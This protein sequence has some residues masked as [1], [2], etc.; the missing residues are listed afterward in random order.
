MSIIVLSSKTIARDREFG[1]RTIITKG[2]AYSVS[3]VARARSG[4]VR[5][6]P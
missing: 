5:L 1:I 4:R 3:F 6:P 2:P